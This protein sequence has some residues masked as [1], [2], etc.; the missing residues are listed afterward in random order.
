MK[1]KIESVAVDLLK[2]V[3]EA[4][5]ERG[6]GGTARS[7]G[8]GGDGHGPPK[9]AR[10]GPLYGSEAKRSSKA[11]SHLLPQ[12]RPPTQAPVEPDVD[13]CAV[14]RGKLQQY[15]DTAFRSVDLDDYPIKGTAEY[16]A[17]GTMKSVYP[18]V[19]KVCRA[20]LSIQGSSGNLE[21]DFCRSSAVI[22]SM[23]ASMDCR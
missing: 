23:R 11:I 13:I 5:V 8:G 2:M 10:V 15:K 4:G 21:R 6:A 7:G 16:W 20:V 9:V 14:A 1:A 19:A 18:E 12:N 3:L 17:T 22:S